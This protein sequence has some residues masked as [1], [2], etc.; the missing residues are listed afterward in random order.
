M[1]VEFPYTPAG[2]SCRGFLL[3]ASN[4][5]T[6]NFKISDRTFNAIDSR[7]PEKY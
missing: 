2:S 7:A 5:S 3:S 6:P 4:F 1:L